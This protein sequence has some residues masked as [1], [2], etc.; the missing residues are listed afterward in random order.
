M[1]FRSF[2]SLSATLSSL[3]LPLSLPLSLPITFPVSVDGE[4]G[5]KEVGEKD[6]KNND[7]INDNNIIINNDYNNNEDDK[8]NIDKNSSENDNNNHIYSNSDKRLSNVVE[9]TTYTI[10]TNSLHAI[11]SSVLA[12]LENIIKM[13]ANRSML[14][15]KSICKI[16]EC[17]HLIIT[18]NKFSATLRNSKFS[19][20]E[21]YRNIL[22]LINK[23]LFP[24]QFNKMKNTLPLYYLPSNIENEKEEIVMIDLISINNENK[25]ENLKF[26]T[27][28]KTISDEDIESESENMKEENVEFEIV[29]LNDVYFVLLKLL[30]L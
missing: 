23:V 30:E 10:P 19:Y 16:I 24:D 7:S 5:E 22:T 17:I 2:S 20:H 3:T 18:S 12:L 8:N 6:V 27:T 28:Q 25:N 21:N 9:L 13:K 14:G 4:R 29:W 1:T 11:Q 26:V 15:E